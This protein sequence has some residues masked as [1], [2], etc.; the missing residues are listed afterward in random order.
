MDH[1]KNL[2]SQRRNQTLINNFLNLTEEDNLTLLYEH[3]EEARIKVKNLDEEIKMANILAADFK[4]NKFMNETKS[5]EET[6]R[7]YMSEF[8]NNVERAVE[9]FRTRD[10]IIRGFAQKNGSSYE[11]AENILRENNYNASVFD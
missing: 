1:F 4:I 9:T 6:A 3:Q 5:N 2:L 10:A 11:V 7:R 8:N